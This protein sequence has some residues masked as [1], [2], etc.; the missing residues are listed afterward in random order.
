MKL[1]YRYKLIIIIILGLI[2]LISITKSFLDA[3]N[4][5]F[6]FHFSPAKLVAEGI[7]HYQYILDGKHDH[8]PD[9]KLMYDQNGNY[10][11]GLFVALI[12][13]TWIGCE[14][15]KFLWS[16][17]NILIAITIPIILSKKFHLNNFQTFIVSSLFLSSTIFRIHIG[18]G[19]QTLLMF[20]FF[21]LPFVKMSNLNILL[22]GI[23]LFKYNIGYGLFL[24]LISLRKLKL[25]L[26]S[27]VPLIIGWLIYCFVTNTNLITNIFEPLRVIL[28][29]NSSE[30]HFPVTIF[31]LLQYLNLS[32]LIILILPVL[33][34]FYL[35]LKLR[36]LKD[37][38]Q[39]LSL[40]CLSILAFTPHQLHDYIL[41]IP[42]LIYSIKNFNLIYSKINIIFILYIFYFL[43]IISLITN[44]QPWDFPYGFV[45]Y[46]N[47]SITMIILL[48]NIYYIN[49]KIS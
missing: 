19:Q 7:N 22:S 10:A 48:M 34:N 18:Y 4:L 16:V 5:S 3:Q 47:N 15:A 43:R 1:I 38:L 17:I 28:Y 13:F 40:L 29:W 12:P 11:Q 14:N 23:A 32:S 20:I 6:D 39:I 8:G 33:L 31:S 24:Y 2:S 37:Q 44:L 46:I 27:L 45:G 25:I 41:L 42:L 26:L 30:S 35:I 21:I 36:I 49:K 9:D